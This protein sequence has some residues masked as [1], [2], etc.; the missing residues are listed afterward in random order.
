MQSMVNIVNVTFQRK[1]LSISEPIC[2]ISN[3]TNTNISSEDM[4]VS[5]NTVRG[6]GFIWVYIK[7]MIM[8]SP[9]RKKRN[10]RM[11]KVGYGYDL[12]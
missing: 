9:N 5:K 10:M 8:E 7:Y 6:R 4:N 11:K 2:N 1:I 12:A 3:I